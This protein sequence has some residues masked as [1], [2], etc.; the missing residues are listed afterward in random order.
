MIIRIAILVI[1]LFA[2]LLLWAGI[3]GLSLMGFD[4]TAARVVDVFITV[5]PAVRKDMSIFGEMT[6]AALSALLIV[7]APALGG[8]R[9]IW[10]AISFV[11]LVLGYAAMLRMSWFIEP[12]NS[13]PI[14]DMLFGDPTQTGEEK[15]RAGAIE[16]LNS[17][18]ESVRTYTAVAAVAVAGFFFKG[19]PA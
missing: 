11:I 10:S 9:S 1:A 13:G 12:N 2:P 5:A 15:L 17:I 4:E 19:D 7:G 16:S 8:R 6:P 14:L 18:V 3:D